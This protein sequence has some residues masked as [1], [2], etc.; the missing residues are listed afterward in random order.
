[1][2]A[3][4]QAWISEADQAS[5]MVGGVPFYEASYAAAAAYVAHLWVRHS[6]RLTVVIEGRELSRSELQAMCER[7]KRDAADRLMAVSVNGIKVAALVKRSALMVLWG[8]ADDARSDAILDKHG[9]F[10]VRI[11]RNKVAR[12]EV[13][14]GLV[15]ISHEDIED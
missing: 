8:A 12:G 15:T 7:G 3:E 1:M 5:V 10:L 11:V 9:D 13:E 4:A 6:D 2:L 14:E